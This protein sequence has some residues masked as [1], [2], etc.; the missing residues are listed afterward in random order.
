MSAVGPR[1]IYRTATS[2]DGYI[3]DSE[4]SLAWL[5]AVENDDAQQ[6]EY[7]RFLEGITVLAEGSTTY[8]WVLRETNLLSEPE[9][10]QG[11]YGERPTFVFTS[12]RLPTPEGA[13]VRF[14][15]GS[16]QDLL[17]GIRAAAAGGDIWLTGGGDLAGQFFEA[18]AL[19]RIDVSIAPVTL[20]SGAP[21]LPRR[22]DSTRLRLAGVGAQG[23]FVVASYEVSR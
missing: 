10:W 12:R 4:D 11:Y 23:Q 22:I 8:E 14:V 19:D 9:R 15:N 5:F 2:L 21:L 20:G 7:R 13:D 6:A 17:P 16:V 1:V 18:A 3:A